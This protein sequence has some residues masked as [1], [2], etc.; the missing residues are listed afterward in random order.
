M[1]ELS[2]CLIHQAMTASDI[3][4]ARGDTVKHRFDRG[5]GTGTVMYVY[6]DGLVAISWF[7][8]VNQYRPQGKTR[9]TFEQPDQVQ[10]T[11]KG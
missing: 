1:G 10:R 11:R 9:M 8:R 6:D 7:K 2:S 4:L 5:Y 3:A